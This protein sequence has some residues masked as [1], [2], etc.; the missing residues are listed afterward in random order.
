MS[1]HLNA[2][3]DSQGFVSIGTMLKARPAE[4][5]GERILYLEASREGVDRQN[6]IVLQKALQDSAADFLKF[7]NID[8]DHMTVPAVAR[9]HGLTNPQEWEIGRPLDV[10][11]PEGRTLVKAQLYQGD[12]P[13][14]RR[15]N[16]VWDSLTK[17]RPPKRWYPSVGGSVLAK[18]MT[19]VD[20]ADH[21]VTVVSK[22][23][24][25]NLA[26]SALPVNPHVAG[27]S[28]V[29]FETL[30][31]SWTGGGL[32]VKG[33]EAS[34][35]TDMAA[36]SGGGALR[37]QSIDRGVA[38]VGPGCPPYD[39]Y[40]DFRDRISKALLEG[41]VLQLAPGDDDLRG[42]MRGEAMRS[43]VP[44][45][46]AAAWVAQFFQDLMPSGAKP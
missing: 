12:T 14:A 31:K 28:T 25:N 30:A 32:I 15:A 45:S 38:Y 18:S 8:I 35:G 39:S 7:G 42:Y 21:P 34:Y 16:D 9:Q 24:W 5:A 10:T 2:S 17:L 27:V 3:S 22:V 33:L 26:I 13:L 20:G 4:E 40:E 29:P 36:L 41:D 11:F 19:Q 23:L 6:E 37:T 46:E 44:R 1:T 43:G